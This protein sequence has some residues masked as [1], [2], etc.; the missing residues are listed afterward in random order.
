MPTEGFTNAAMQWGTDME[1]EA[2]A[3]YEF[4]RAEEVEQV[5]FATFD[6]ACR[7]IT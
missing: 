6:T 4:Y 7:R 5:A 1:P 2:R 3:A